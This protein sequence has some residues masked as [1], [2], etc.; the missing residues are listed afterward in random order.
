MRM[1][2]FKRNNKNYMI[3]YNQKLKERSRLLR[4]KMTDT[5]RVLWGKIKNRQLK[6]AQFYRQKIVGNYIVDF[7]CS[8]YKLVIELDG[9]QH[10][11]KE[12]LEYDL[13]RDKFIESNDIKILR[14]SNQEVLNN[15]NEVIK[16]IINEMI[17]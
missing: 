16:S 14:F 6:D 10:Y 9:S 2:D 3:T 8:K 13:Y 12:G 1:G 4:S 7:Y 15:L 17:N 11:T 5:E